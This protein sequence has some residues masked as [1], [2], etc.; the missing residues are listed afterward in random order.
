IHPVFDIV[1]LLHAPPNPI[2]RWKTEPPPPPELVDGEE[3]YE[4]EQVLDSR[5]FCNRL[6]YL[7][8]WKG[9]GYEE[10][11]WVANVSTRSVCTQT[12]F[13][14]SHPN[15]PCRIHTTAFNSLDFRQIR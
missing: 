8:K 9:Y 14:L 10:N 12:K 7:V 5:L 13:H 2:P 4:V 6:E 1:K 15:A 11:S 3:H